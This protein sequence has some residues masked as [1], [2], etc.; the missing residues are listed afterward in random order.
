MNSPLIFLIDDDTDLAKAVSLTLEEHGFHVEYSEDGPT[1]LEKL[2]TIT[3]DIFLIDL[4]MQPMNGFELYQQI[5]THSHL[6][7]IPV[8]FLTA[9]NDPI[10]E[11]YSLKLG[12]DA[13]LTKPIDM[14]E[15]EQAIK[16]KLKLS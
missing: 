6:V 5:K 14:D 3:P 4:R 2:K 11:R 9:V 8:F 1:A 7:H 16:K 10:A 13:Y 15:L 12:V